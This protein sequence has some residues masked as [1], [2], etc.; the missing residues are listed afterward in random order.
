MAN[1]IRVRPN[2]C[3]GTITN[4]PLAAGGTTLNSAALANLPAIGSSEHCVLV[5]DPLGAGAGPEI[6]HVTAHTASAT[7]ATIARGREGTTGVQHATG[8]AWIAGPVASD[9]LSVVSSSATRPSTTGLPYEGQLIYQQ[10]TKQLLGYTTSTTGWQEPWSL[11][12][13]IV[14]YA[15]RTSN[16]TGIGTSATDVTS[17]SVTATYVAN[18]RI[19]ITAFGGLAS[20]GTGD[21]GVLYIRE[22]TTTLQSASTA[23]GA[24][25]SFA[26]AAL[27]P[28]VI[29]TPTAGSHTYKV[30]A[31]Q[32]NATTGTFTASSTAPGFILIED[33]GPSANPA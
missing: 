23:S 17:L 30:S 8:T 20:G 13:G 10:D 12:W 24:L 4:N 9:Y 18:R 29:V 14:G 19:K 16:V 31:S 3:S 21:S 28:I 15:S 33:I 32:T 27:C 26:G 11:P 7:S 5:L 6:V 2:F 1:E 22:S 25:S